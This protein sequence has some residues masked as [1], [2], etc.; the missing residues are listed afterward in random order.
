MEAKDEQLSLRDEPLPPLSFEIKAPEDYVT[1]C[2]ETRVLISVLIIDEEINRIQEAVQPYLN[3]LQ[4]QK[5]ALIERAKK[6]AIMEDLGAVMVEVKGKLFRNEIE[7]VEKFR[8]TF[9]EGYEQI[10]DSQKRDIED[11]HQKNLKDLEKS[12]IPLI[13]A[14]KKIGKDATTAFVGYR[15][16]TITYEIQKK[17]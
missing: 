16:Q 17:E 1:N 2:P 5:N 7:D 9:P 8:Q 11:K 15:P 4:A 6:E 13:L 14:D 12:K 3:N 10:R